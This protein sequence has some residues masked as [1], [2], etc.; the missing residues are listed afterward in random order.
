M[1]WS[2]IPTI[3][4]KEKR[5]HA[6]LLDAG[7]DSVL[8]LKVSWRGRF[9]RHA[10]IIRPVIPAYVF[11]RVAQHEI[12]GFHDDGAIRAIPVPKHELRLFEQALETIAGAALFGDY[13]DAE[14][15]APR[16]AKA[17]L[18]PKN[19][20]NRNRKARRAKREALEWLNGLK[21]IAERLDAPL[22]VAA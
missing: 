5:L 20:R 15:M 11:A 14:P 7:Y 10:E 8:P 9:A 12:H 3:A 16:V 4:S 1:S 17:G 22:D 6:S 21:A 13:D 2:I 19:P 18:P